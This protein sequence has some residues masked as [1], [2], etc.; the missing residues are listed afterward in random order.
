MSTVADIEAAIERLSAPQVDELACWLE[1]LRLKRAT[2]PPVESWLD[3][4]RGAASQDV[5][6]KSIM[7]LTRVEE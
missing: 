3:N 7:A 5:T 1:T 2:P 6:T 4:A